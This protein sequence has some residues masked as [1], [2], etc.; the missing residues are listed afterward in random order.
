MRT[1]RLWWAAMPALVFGVAAP[2]GWAQGLKNN[3]AEEAAL[4]KKS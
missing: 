3:S 4:Q 2:L 1:R